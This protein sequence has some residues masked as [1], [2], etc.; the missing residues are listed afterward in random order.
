MIPQDVSLHSKFVSR[1]DGED[2]VSVSAFSE[3]YRD[4]VSPYRVEVIADTVDAD[5][6]NRITTI[7][8]NFPRCVL[9]ELN[10]HRVFSRNS[11]SSRAKSAKVTMLEVLHT[12]YIPIFTENRKGMSGDFLPHE[13]HSVAVERVLHHRDTSLAGLLTLLLGRE[14]ETGQIRDVATAEALIDEYYQSVYLAEEKPEHSLNIHKQNINRYLEPFMWHEVVI[15][16][17]MWEN[18][19]ELRNHNDADPAIHIVGAMIDTALENSLPEVSQ[20]HAPFARDWRN[21]G[22]DWE[23]ILAAMNR[24]AGSAAQVSY[25][26]VGNNGKLVNPSKLADRLLEARHMSPFEHSAVSPELLPNITPRSNLGGYWIQHR[27][28]I[29]EQNFG[30]QDMSFV[31]ESLHN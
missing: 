24:T 2:C 17:T 19:L 31:S 22:S 20:V 29:D 10:T 9:S 8:A 28:L 23:D 30:T 12:P 1:Q 26:P 11:A 15:T 21:A 18:F 25:R 7:V 6:N 5:N 3:L 13:Q 4:E 27:Q 14:I 16:S